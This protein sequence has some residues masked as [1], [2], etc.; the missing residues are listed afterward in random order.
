M[1]EETKNS[2]V[3]LNI[4]SAVI[5]LT[6]FMLLLLTDKLVGPVINTTSAPNED[7]V[8]ASSIPIFPLE[9]LP[10]KRTASM[11][12]YVGPP[13]IKIFFPKSFK[14]LCISFSIKLII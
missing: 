14:P 11:G 6:T 13:V 1:S 2:L 3:F 7:A 12:S 9:K 5:T 10:I 4:S 8:L